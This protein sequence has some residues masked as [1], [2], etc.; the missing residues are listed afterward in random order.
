MTT[1]L[2]IG[3]QKYSYNKYVKYNKYIKIGDEK[4]WKIYIKK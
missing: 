2:N 1:T 3:T 4:L